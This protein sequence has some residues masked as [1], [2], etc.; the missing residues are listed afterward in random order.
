MWLVMLEDGFGPPLYLVTVPSAKDWTTSTSE[1][2]VFD[3][4]QKR[5][6]DMPSWAKWA[7]AAKP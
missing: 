4:K 7:R 2:R 5:G 6:F 3:E 1:A